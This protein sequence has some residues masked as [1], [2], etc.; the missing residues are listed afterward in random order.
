MNQMSE[1]FE[2]AKDLLRQKDYIQ[3]EEVLK[4]ILVKN[5]KHYN[6]IIQL[7]LLEKKKKEYE[8]S[9]NL[10]FKA[11]KYKPNFAIGY[12]YL[13]NLFL[14]EK[15]LEE[16]KKY[17]EKSVE[18]KPNFFKAQVQLGK[19]Y[20]L[21]KYSSKSIESYKKALEL[22][23]NSINTLLS[24][25]KTLTK[26]PYEH[27]EALNIYKKVLQID[28]NS[29]QA[30]NGIGICYVSKKD[31]DKAISFFRKAIELKPG[32][33]SAHYNLGLSLLKIG[34]F[35]EGFQEYDW[36]KYRKK[37]YV[38]QE[39]FKSLEWKGET[40]NSKTILVHDEQGYGDTVQFSRY[41][42]RLCEEYEVNIL[43]KTKEKLSYLY[44][45]SPFK[46]LTE[47]SSIPQHHF[48]SD[49]INLVKIYY[50]KTNEFLKEKD[51]LPS[52]RVLE[53]KWERKLSKLKGPKI[54]LNW[55]GNKFRRQDKY[56]AVKLDFLEPL[57]N[58][59]S[60]LQFV[61]VQKG[62]GAEQVDT[63][64]FKKE[65]FYKDIDVDIEKELNAFEDSIALIKQLNLLITVDTAIAHIAS[66]LGVET[67]LLLSDRTDWRWS[68][69]SSKSPWYKNMTLYRQKK[70]GDWSFPIRNI[71]Q[72]LLKLFPLK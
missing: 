54:G 62:F 41:I 39:I 2:K 8:K 28:P 57:F 56:R 23:P 27:E 35:E 67:W 33:I 1:L 14:K 63:F 4:K 34:E 72:D 38:N 64:R 43:F 59:N 7:G 30:L 65:L 55:Q 44:K 5:P 18:L 46:I 13:G 22:R 58:E 15:N 17:F 24:L 16:A 26:N 11:V 70:L 49:M 36:R 53:E 68:I 47:K 29:S 40:L 60:N 51:F 42:F 12:F 71:Q 69:K 20:T 3:A 21:L 48:H 61:S 31:F 19:T 66:T 52:N 45:D 10:F 25:A 6:S 9:R 50:L 37:R 32:L